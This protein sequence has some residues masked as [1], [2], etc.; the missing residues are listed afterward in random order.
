MTFN[1]N[2]SEKDNLKPDP[3]FISY[4]DFLRHTYD[5]PCSRFPEDCEPREIK[6]VVW[7]AD[8]TLWDIK[9]FGLASSC[10]PPFR[11]VADGIVEC[12]PISTSRVAKPARVELKPNVKKTIED[13]KAR[14][15]GSSVA[16]INRPGS[17]ETLLKAMGVDKDFDMIISDHRGKAEMV[18]NIALRLNI[19][20]EQVLFVDDDAWNCEEVFDSLNTLSLV[21]GADIKDAS[22]ILRFIK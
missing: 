9:P 22:E 20:Y 21:M 18:A 8:D 14:G 7:D 15:I 11:K 17:V 2:P 3:N 1:G 13:L 19:P 10:D 4:K 12:G 6:H 16:S 5:T